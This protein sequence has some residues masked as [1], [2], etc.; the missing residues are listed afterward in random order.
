[1]GG[2]PQNIDPPRFG[3]EASHPLYGEDHGKGAARDR[4]DS[5]AQRV[6]KVA[7]QPA[8]KTG[9]RQENRRAPSREQQ[10]CNEGRQKDSGGHRV[11]RRDKGED[12]KQQGL[13]EFEHEV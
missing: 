9:R 12:D 2:A 7:R 3:R 4:R 1:M 13:K 8:P 5:G 6:A 11:K 10:Q